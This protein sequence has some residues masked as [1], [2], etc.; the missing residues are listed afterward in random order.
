MPC[1]TVFNNN[2][3]FLELLIPLLPNVNI[4]DR[5]G[6]TSLQHA[7]YNGHFEVRNVV[8]SNIYT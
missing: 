4:T 3:E 5:A 7:V 2:F 6:R 1:T 8:R